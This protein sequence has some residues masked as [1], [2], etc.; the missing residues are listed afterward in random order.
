MELLHNDVESLFR[1]PDFDD[2]C[3]EFDRNF[4]AIVIKK[5]I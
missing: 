3:R 4:S 2:F 1:T 5:L